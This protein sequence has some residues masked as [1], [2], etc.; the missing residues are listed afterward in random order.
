MKPL[1]LKQTDNSCRHPCNVPW[2]AS[3]K[4]SV[5]GRDKLIHHL[6]LPLIPSVNSVFSTGWAGGGGRK[7]RR[8]R[9][10]E[11]WREGG[12]VIRHYCRSPSLAGP[13]ALHLPVQHYRSGD[14]CLEEREEMETNLQ[15]AQSRRKERDLT[16]TSATGHSV[17]K[18]RKTWW[19]SDLTF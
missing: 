11:V 18:L 2:T 6:S 16:C 19:Q 5:P 14:R 17:I 4:S 9:E 7:K 13:S 10:T 1:S 15:W 8:K 3:E 12:N